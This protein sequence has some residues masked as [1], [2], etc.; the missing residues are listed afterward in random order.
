MSD[1][2]ETLVTAL[3]EQAARQRGF[4]SDTMA[5]A[6][7]QVAINTIRE[8]TS[9]GS[10]ASVPALASSEDGSWQA[11]GE[12]RWYAEQMNTPVQLQQAWQRAGDGQLQW[13]PVPLAVEGN[14]RTGD[15]A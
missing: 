7:A 6:L 15:P 13:R 8:S 12:L 11:T 5:R 10:A 2:V 14:P 1:L 9:R 3:Q 4:L